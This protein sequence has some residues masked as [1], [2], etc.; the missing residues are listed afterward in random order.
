MRE[1]HAAL[2][3][4]PSRLTALIDEHPEE[5]PTA[6]SLAIHVSI[7][8]MMQ[9]FARNEAHSVLGRARRSAIRPPLPPLP[10]ASHAP[11]PRTE[12]ACW[13][14]QCSAEP[15]LRAYQDRTGPVSRWTY[16]AQG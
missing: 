12:R 14:V 4:S 10:G 3:A 15:I 7:A 5:H 8:A 2:V 11:M 16:A 9:F 6:V 13:D 1:L